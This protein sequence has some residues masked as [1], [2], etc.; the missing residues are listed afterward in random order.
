MNTITKTCDCHVYGFD[1]SIIEEENAFYCVFSTTGKNGP[2]H[3]KMKL[4]GIES[5][6]KI[7]LTVHPEGTNK[8]MNLIYTA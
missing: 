1:A 4:D 3:H 7:T 8:F 6:E 2:V 5:R